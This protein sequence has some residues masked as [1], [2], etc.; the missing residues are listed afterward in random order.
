MLYGSGGDGDNGIRGGDV[1][2]DS[3]WAERT[4]SVLDSVSDLYSDSNVSL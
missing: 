3:Y 4:D 1:G 2:S